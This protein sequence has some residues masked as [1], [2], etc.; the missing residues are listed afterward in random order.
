MDSKHCWRI[1][2][3][4][5]M[6]VGCRDNSW[7]ASLCTHTITIRPGKGIIGLWLWPDVGLWKSPIPMWSGIEIFGAGQ[8]RVGLR[9]SIIDYGY[10]SDSWN[11]GPEVLFEIGSPWN[12]WMMM[13]TGTSL[14]PRTQYQCSRPA[15]T[16]TVY[17]A[18]RTTSAESTHCHCRC[19]R[20]NRC[21]C[22]SVS[23]TV[24]VRRRN[25]CASASV[26][27]V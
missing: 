15:N 1:Q 9:I 27:D 22:L 20:V 13:M 18:A 7:I 8:V 4:L 10:E 21:S 23:L 24:T 6:D 17:R 2:D 12:L 26:Y 14:K 16:G 5:V 25:H 11:C 19:P 3:E